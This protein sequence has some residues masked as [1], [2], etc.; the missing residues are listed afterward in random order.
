MNRILITG[1]TGFLGRHLLW[2]N[3]RSIEAPSDDRII[4][5][6]RADNQKEANSRLMR[7]LNDS[8][9]GLSEMQKQHAQAMVGD[10]SRPRL[11]LTK[12]QLAELA[13]GLTDVIHCAASVK[14]TLDIELARQINVEGTKRILEV[15]R[16]AQ[17]GG[18]LRRFD[19]VGT[20]YVAGNRK[21]LVRE[22]ELIM[23][24]EF[25]N[26]YEQTKAESEQVAR[27]ASK[28]LPVT[29]FRPSVVVGHSRTGITQ[30]FNVM[31]WPLKV[32]ARRLVLCIPADR[33]GLVDIVPIDF[34]TN[35]IEWVRNHTQPE[36][37]CYHIAAGPNKAVTVGTM[38]EKTAKF[39]GVWTPP[40]V[41]PQ[42]FH[43]ILSPIFKIIL[44]GPY[45]RV[46]D[47]GTQY[48]PYLSYRAI[49]D[50][51]NLQE[52]LAGSGVST[53]PV[54]DYFDK[55]MVY[56]QESEWGKR[57]VTPERLETVLQERF[58]AT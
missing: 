16:L 37:K 2:H 19:Y 46:Y 32:F 27:Q 10:L 28:E 43:K 7:T 20:A 56:C 3:L 12:K 51:T 58:S 41:S 49:F 4:C 14:F 29:I 53:L 22:D 33:E 54:T 11:G 35:S 21:G 6:I 47:I 48:I 34:V 31:Y 5:L 9:S 23:D 50:T 26:T 17:S 44:R 30:S 38:V 45:K 8:Q 1:V 36:G 42:T 15:A 52:A 40:Y 39:F 57:K 55:L 13:D 24:T 25:N 18:S